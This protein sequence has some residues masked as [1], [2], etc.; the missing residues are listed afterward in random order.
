MHSYIRYTKNCTY[1]RPN[2]A[3]RSSITRTTSQTL[4]EIEKNKKRMNQ[5]MTLLK[6]TQNRVGRK[7]QIPVENSIYT[8]DW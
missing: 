8:S 5:E 1:R 6:H 3:L 4:S 7:K 2:F